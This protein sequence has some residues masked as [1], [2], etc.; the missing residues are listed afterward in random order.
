M[1]KILLNNVPLN[2]YIRYTEFP[3]Y[4]LDHCEE[5]F[6]CTLWPDQYYTCSKP[7]IIARS[8]NNIS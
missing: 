4:S 5:H 6:M 1:E 7:E 8:N 3:E 2:L